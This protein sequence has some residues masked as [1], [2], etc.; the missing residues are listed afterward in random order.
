MY[1]YEIPEHLDVDV[2]ELMIG[3]GIRLRDLIADVKW[4]PVSDPDTLLV[5]VIAPKVEEEEAEAEAEAEAAATEPAVEGAE[6]EVIQEGQ[7]RRRGVKAE[8][9]GSSVK[10]IVGLGI[11]ERSTG[12]TRH[13]VGFEVVDEMAQRFNLEFES[14]PADAVMA[15]E[16]GPNAR[17]MLA[18]PLTFMNRSGHATW[19]LAR[20]YRIALDDLLIVTDDANLP[21]G[22]LRA[23]PEGSDGGTTDC[24]RSLSCSRPSRCRAFESVSARAIHTGV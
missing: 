19:A 2:S 13:N 20:F 1:A 10:L 22:R 17:V 11:R 9:G 23:R 16:R 3:D 14:S 21:L 4:T 24:V 12:G 15:K 7:G 5:H 18:K 6:P 8:I